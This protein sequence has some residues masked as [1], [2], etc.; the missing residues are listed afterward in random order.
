MV[1]ARDEGSNGQ[2]CGHATPGD[3]HEAMSSRLETLRGMIAADPKNSFVRYALATELVKA[4]QVQDAVAEFRG[5]IAE[6]PNYSAAYYHGG[7]ALESLGDLDAARSLYEEG[8]AATMKNGDAHT[9]SE[10]QAAL[11]LL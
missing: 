8:I 2:K 7:R 11:D 10:L 3:Y 9:R 6:D 1:I 4:G 5:L